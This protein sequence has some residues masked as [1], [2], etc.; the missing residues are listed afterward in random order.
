MDRTWK[1]VALALPAV[2]G[3]AVSAYAMPNRH[4]PAPPPTTTVV[5]TTAAATTTTAPVTTTNPPATMTDPLA[6]MNPPVT[7]T[8][9]APAPAAKIVSPLDGTWYT[10]G[11]TSIFLVR[12]SGSDGSPASCLVDW[13]DGA[14]SN[15]MCT[16][17]SGTCASTHVYMKSG[18][19]TITFTGTSRDGTPIVADPVQVN[20]I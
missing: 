3:L 7:T 10:R 5:A 12:V 1:L 6:T 11:S 9:A 8:L 2:L 13:G 17:N 4:R 16:C 14:T 15:G 20:V 18:Q 19:F